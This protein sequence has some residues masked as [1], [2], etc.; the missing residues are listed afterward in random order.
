MQDTG[1][2]SDSELVVAALGDARTYGLLVR[3]WES[4]LGRYVRRILGRDGQA[5]DDVLQEVFLK[6]YVNLHDFDR[7]RPFGPWI[8][9]IRTQ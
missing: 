8:Y 2:P 1:S 7:T 3:R 4:Q 5:A 9:R 6:A